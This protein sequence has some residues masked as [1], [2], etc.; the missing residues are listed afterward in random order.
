MPSFKQGWR[1]LSNNFRDK[2]SPK[3]ESEVIRNS[4]PSGDED[5]SDAFIQ[6]VF[7]P[8][9]FA[10]ATNSSSSSPSG[11]RGSDA[12]RLGPERK[13][14][15]EKAPPLARGNRDLPES[16]EFSS[17]RGHTELPALA[18]EYEQER[19]SQGGVSYEKRRN[20]S[21]ES[22]DQRMGSHVNGG[23]QTLAPLVSEDH[24]SAEIEVQQSNNQPLLRVP[25]E[26]W[27]LTV[28]S[29]DPCSAASLACVNRQISQLLGPEVWTTLN[30]PSNRPHKVRFL[31]FLE[32]FYPKHILC[33]AC[34]IYHP[35][36]NLGKE[37]RLFE[38]TT[39]TNRAK[40][41]VAH[42]TRSQLIPSVRITF[43]LAL[44]FTL[45][46]LVT[47]RH[48]HGNSPEWGMPFS[49]LSKSW[50]PT[51]SDWTTTAEWFHRARFVI[52]KRGHLLMK[53]SSTF[54]TAADLADCERRL[55]LSCRKDYTA[56]YSTCPHEALGSRLFRICECALGHIPSAKS[57]LSG[58]K[59][60]LFAPSQRM[61]GGGCATCLPL[62]RCLV[63]PTEYKID[64][65]LKECRIGR[66][67]VAFRHAIVVTRWSDLGDAWAPDSPEWRACSSLNAS[68]VTDE[69]DGEF[70]RVEGEGLKEK[71]VR[72]RFE[73]AAGGRLSE[74]DA[75]P[76]RRRNTRWKVEKE[77]MRDDDGRLE[78]FLRGY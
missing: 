58:G 54:W 14:P 75:V 27:L 18:R 22:Q 65:Q 20:V 53:V 56:N 17:T 2:P 64:V 39:V 43:D 44:P 10:H 21:I 4:N 23:G 15:S 8:V 70:F 31:Q 1:K 48:R 61:G 33:H 50:S 69:Y 25:T 38:S 72:N 6:Q 37:Q 68:A 60:N 11:S 42:C 45:A 26:L 59:G 19:E 34:G 57:S 7:S 46:H 41:S 71:T 30:N 5:S 74:V 40:K 28:D 63:C 35:R 78:M 32:P 76:L 36:R 49:A 24:L 29:L 66:G 62:Y 13:R 52:D 12:P 9:S 16:R 73:N 67:D 55:A 3:N 51:V 77:L 47:Q